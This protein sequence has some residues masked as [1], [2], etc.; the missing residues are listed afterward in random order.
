MKSKNDAQP[1]VNENIQSQQVQL[2]SQDGEN[3]GVVPTDRAIMLAEEASLD[4]VVIADK[5]A[6]G[7]PVAKIMDFGKALYAKKK[8]LIESKKH[9]KTVQI[10]EIKM[11]PK[12]GEHDYITKIKHAMQF[13]QSGKKLKITLMFRGR[14]MATRAERGAE[15]FKKVMGTF[16]E[17]G[18]ADVEMEK[19]TRGGQMWSRLFY[20]KSS[21]QD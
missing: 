19:E 1:L 8:K 15:M 4:L 11:R 20:M 16:A 2:I 5:G 10:K 9:Q 13:L 18:L 12:I 7:V 21:A 3:V 14:E 6:A 17:L